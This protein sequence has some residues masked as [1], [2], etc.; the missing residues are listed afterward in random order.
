MVDVGV[1][2]HYGGRV[3]TTYECVLLGC[4][5]LLCTLMRTIVTDRVAW[6]VAWSVTLVSPAKTT[7]PTEMPFGLWARM[8]PRNH[9]LDGSPEMLRDVAMAT[10]F[11]LSIHGV[12]NGATW[13]IQLNRPCAAT[14][15]PYDV[16]LL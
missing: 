5:A 8:G 9:V 14:M 7:E 15:R 4:M 2:S 10:I 11:W 16:K 6:S 12:H 1:Y 13:R 3:R